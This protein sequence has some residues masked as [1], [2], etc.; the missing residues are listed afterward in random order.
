MLQ[1][2]FLVLLSY[3]SKREYKLFG[4]SVHF[5]LHAMMRLHMVPAYLGLQPYLSKVTLAS[6]N[7]RQLLEINSQGHRRWLST[8]RVA[9]L[10]TWQNYVYS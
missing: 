5:R 9:L 2:E 7:E 10:A 6:A 8:K 3:P 4:A 1:A